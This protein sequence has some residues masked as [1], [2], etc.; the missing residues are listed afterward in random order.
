MNT[1]TEIDKKLLKE[2]PF[3]MKL[4]IRGYYSALNTHGKKNIWIYY[5]N[6]FMKIKEKMEQ[7][8]NSLQNFL[9][10]GKVVFDRNYTFQ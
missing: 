6:T 1:D 7:T 5:M 2:L 10:S 3:I 4:C 9:K 8:T